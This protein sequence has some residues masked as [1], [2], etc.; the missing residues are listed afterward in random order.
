MS[1]R[2][3]KTISLIKI[4]NSAYEINPVFSLHDDGIE[5]DTVLSL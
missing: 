5:I 1:I 4:N 3:Y 2:H